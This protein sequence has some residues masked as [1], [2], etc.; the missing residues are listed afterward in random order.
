[1]NAV[2]DTSKPG[3]GATLAIDINELQS[4]LGFPTQ[5]QGTIMKLLTTAATLLSLSIIPTLAQSAATQANPGGP[6]VGVGWGQM[7]LDLHNLGD[8][9]TATSNIVKADDNAWKLFAGWRFNP[10]LAFEAAYIDFGRP[11]DRFDSSGSNGNYKVE[12]SGFAPYVI[13][14]IPLG[15]AELFAKAGSYFY[16]V[17]VLVDFDNPGPE[18]RSSHS[19]NDFLYGGGIGYTFMD[20]LHVRA[21]YEVVHLKH[22]SNSQAIWLSGAWRF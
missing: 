4:V 9:G 19:R 6:Y 17:D 5:Y 13:G 10:Y 14:S 7:N 20:H 2:N 3:F 8:V 18:L 12:L 16:D 11:S 22:A 21:E 15:N 1:L